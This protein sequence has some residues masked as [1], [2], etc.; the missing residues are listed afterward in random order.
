MVC[1]LIWEA[2]NHIT[3]DGFYADVCSLSFG[4]LG[5]PIVK[6]LSKRIIIISI[7]ECKRQD[8]RS[9]QQGGCGAR[10]GQEAQMRCQ[11]RTDHATMDPARISKH[12]A[13]AWHLVLNKFIIVLYHLIIWIYFTRFLSGGGKGWDGGWR[14]QYWQAHKYM[15]YTNTNGHSSFI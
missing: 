6:T 3:L 11:G 5:I 14:K 2:L 8:A 12:V 9:G 13:L 7:A 10:V 15:E 4:D 1:R